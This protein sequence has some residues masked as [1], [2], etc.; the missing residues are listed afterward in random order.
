M[1]RYGD[2]TGIYRGV[3]LR[4]TTCRWAAA[5]WGGGMSSRLH[6]ITSL[7]S[8]VLPGVT[9]SKPQCLGS[10]RACAVAR[11]AV[12]CVRSTRISQLE[13]VPWDQ[14]VPASPRPHRP[15]GT[16][17]LLPVFMTLASLDSTRQRSQCVL[18][19]CPQ[20]DLR[21]KESGMKHIR[22]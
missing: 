10:V 16:A 4:C 8:H 5:T 1:Q 11:V 2:R 15:P 18:L 14:D 9:S 17:V 7:S 22:K 21:H 3:R 6:G 19:R 20:R 12:T 13:L